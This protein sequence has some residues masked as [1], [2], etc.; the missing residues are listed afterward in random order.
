[1]PRP[2]QHADMTR[3]SRVAGAI[4]LPA[5]MACRITG[6]V[7]CDDDGTVFLCGCRPIESVIADIWDHITEGSLLATMQDQHERTLA[8]ETR[9]VLR[10][11]AKVLQRL[12]AVIGIVCPYLRRPFTIPLRYVR[13]GESSQ[14]P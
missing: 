13:I 3:G 10:P 6:C 11:I 7:G 1:M 2:R 8:S 9:R 12:I 5:V 4:M 14:T